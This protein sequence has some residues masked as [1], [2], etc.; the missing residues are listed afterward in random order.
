MKKKKRRP[1]MVEEI[2]QESQAK[3]PTDVLGS[4]T[5]VRHLQ[6]VWTIHAIASLEQEMH[7]RESW[8]WWRVG[9]KTL[10]LT[11]PRTIPMLKWKDWLKQLALWTFYIIICLAVNMLI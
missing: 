5:G 7:Y 11:I 3:H 1:E 8:C 4:W 9:W 2:L 6:M 10:I